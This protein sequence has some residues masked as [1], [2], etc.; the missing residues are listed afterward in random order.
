MK[1]FE[2]HPLIESFETVEEFFASIN[3]N[4]SD[5]ILTNSFLYN[6]GDIDLKG[7]QIVY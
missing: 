2:L 3:L 4:E 6:W 1:L 7:S 5:L